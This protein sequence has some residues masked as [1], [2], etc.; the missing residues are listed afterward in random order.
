[1]AGDTTMLVPVPAALAPQPLAYHCQVPPVP[2]LPP[3]TV[4][5]L[6]F[7]EQMAPA[8]GLAEAGAV[9][10]AFTL[11]VMLEQTVVLQEP[12]AFTK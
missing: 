12:T 9:D 11:T 2:R 8:D 1:M 3:L 5:V 10:T 6:L 7:P 4:S